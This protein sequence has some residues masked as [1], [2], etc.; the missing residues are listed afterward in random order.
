MDGLSA[1]VVP[2]LQQLMPGFLAM[3]V[4][5][6]FAEA[7]KPAVLE[8]VLQALI[9]TTLIQ[10]I[11]KGIEATSYAIGKYFT[12]GDWSESSATGSS[13][14]IAL[15]VG[16][17]LAHLCNNDTIFNIA[18]KSKLTTRASQNDIVHIH[19]ALANC[20]VVLHFNDRRR[21][22]GYLEAYPSALQSGV[23]LVSSPVWVTDETM[24]IDERV[25][26]IMINAAD[27]QWVE[28]LN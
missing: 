10:F 20:G 2:V 8:K 15:V 6:W 21:L 28:F 9:A 19:K 7:Q 1:E 27:I 11:V 23:Y 14:I 13:M 22:M 16:L 4:F 5:Y 12:L 26:S 18:R 24:Q 17:G 25:K 3:L